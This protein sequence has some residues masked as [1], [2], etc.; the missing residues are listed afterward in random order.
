[1]GV[2]SSPPSPA[3]SYCASAHERSRRLTALPSHHHRVHGFDWLVTRGHASAAARGLAP[4]RLV[5]CAKT[6]KGASSCTTSNS[7]A[8]AR[9]LVCVFGFINVCLLLPWE[10]GHPC[11]PKRA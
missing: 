4:P 3:F 11:P 1:M 9:A 5:L 2:S 8:K 10:R 7:E 6:L